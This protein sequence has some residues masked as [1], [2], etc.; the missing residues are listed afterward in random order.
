MKI[1]FCF[2]IVFIKFNF[3]YQKQ[4]GFLRSNPH[5]Y[6]TTPCSILSGPRVVHR[7]ATKLFHVA[8]SSALL[9][10]SSFWRFFRLISRER[11]RRQVSF[12]LPILLVLPGL[13]LRACLVILSVGNLRTWPY[14]FQSASL[15]FSTTLCWP[16]FLLSSSS[17]MMN[18]RYW[19]TGTFFQWNNQQSTINKLDWR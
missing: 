11:V 12:G 13:Q 10:T 4:Q 18:P 16:I 7:S 15:F 2:K 5:P 9:H 6:T 3:F 8:L 19:T 14:H 17:T 1:E